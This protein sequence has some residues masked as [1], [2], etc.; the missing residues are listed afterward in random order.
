VE[1]GGI[2]LGQARL[3][4]GHFS[5]FWRV[6]TGQKMLGSRSVMSVGRAAQLPIKTS[7]VINFF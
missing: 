2:G 5:R 4:C 6:G 7:V 1:K 3:N